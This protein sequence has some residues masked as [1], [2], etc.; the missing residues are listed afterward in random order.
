MRSDSLEFVLNCLVKNIYETCHWHKNMGEQNRSQNN[1][2]QAGFE[3]RHT[4][5][6]TLHYNTH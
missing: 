6:Y 3:A 1:G 4:T 2:K 5:H